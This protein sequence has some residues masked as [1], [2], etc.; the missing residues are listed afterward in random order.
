MGEMMFR[1]KQLGI[2]TSKQFE[3][4]RNDCRMKSFSLTQTGMADKKLFSPR[5]AK[6]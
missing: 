6:L 4:F 5:G 1:E 2:V 3:F